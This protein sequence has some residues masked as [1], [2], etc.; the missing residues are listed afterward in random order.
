MELRKKDVRFIINYGIINNYLVAVVLDH[1]IEVV[2]EI[3]VVLV[4]VEN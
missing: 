3:G 4:A 2:K 1:I